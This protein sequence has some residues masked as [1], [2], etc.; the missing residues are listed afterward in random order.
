MV[1]SQSEEKGQQ[2]SPQ[3]SASCQTATEPVLLTAPRSTLSRIHPISDSRPLPPPQLQPKSKLPRLHY[4]GL[5]APMVH[6]F[7]SSLPTTMEPEPKSILLHATAKSHPLTNSR[8][9][10]QHLNL[11]P[12]RMNQRQKEPV[13]LLQRFSS[14]LAFHQ[15]FFAKYTI[16]PSWNSMFTE[17]QIAHYV[18]PGL[19]SL[20]RLV[21]LPHVTSRRSSS[22]ISFG[23]YLHA[24][25]HLKRK[26]D[27]KP[28]RTRMM[29]H[30]KAL[31]WIA[32]KLDLPILQYLQS[33][34][35]S[36]F[37]KSQTRIPFERSEAT[38]IPLAVLA[39]WEQRI[40][41]SDSSLAEVL[42]LG[43]FLVATM[44]S[45][46]FRDLLRTKPDS[47]SVQDFI[48]RGI[49]WRTKTSVSGQPWGY[50]AWEYQPD[51]PS[52]IGSPAS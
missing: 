24:S 6:C 3:V 34:T 38:P 13:Q 52:V 32:S 5:P 48:L 27:S 50:V 42:T 46:R 35:V 10:L 7:Q 17:S 21:P 40:I 51:H 4:G 2:P 31:R 25:D 37:L 16:L 26:K 23:L 47:L 44:A 14:R 43:C 12:T 1:I 19:A 41:S 33:Q 15:S 29:T 45:L 49:S 36:D 9:A 11:H 20:G 8:R 22:I 30:I 28:S 39:A 18:S